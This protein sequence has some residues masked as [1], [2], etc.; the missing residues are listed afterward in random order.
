MK[1]ADVSIKRPVF[2]LM[3]SAA[4]VV[5]GV[6]SYSQLGLDLMPKTDM[7]VVFVRTSLPGASAEEIETQI[8][9]PIEEVVNTIA[10]I[11]ELRSSSEQ[12]SSRVIIMFV[13][14]RDIEA[15]VQDVRD[16]VA[17]ITSR[18]P[19]DTFP[20]TVQKI[21][22][23][24]SPILTVAISGDR[25]QKEISEIV[26]K[27][28]KQV[29]ET[30]NDVGEVTFTGDRRREIQLLLNKDRMVA[31]NLTIDQVRS[32]VQRQNVEI[33][34]GSFIAGSSE[35]ALRTMGRIQKVEDFEKII[36]AYSGGSVIT[37]GDIGRVLDTVEEP[38]SVA[39]M[40]GRQAVSLMVRK[41]SG[42]NTVKVVEAVMARLE[43][44]KTTLPPDLTIQTTQDQS[45][46]I[47]RSFEEIQRHLLL[48]GLL[49]S[50]V[51]LLFMRNFRTTVIA[52][53]AIPTSIIGAFT[54]MRA[55]GFTMNNMTMLALSLATGIVIDDAIVVLENIFRYIEEKKVAPKEAASKAT[56]EIGLAVMATTL[57]LVVIFLP[58]AFMTGQVGRYF[59]SFGIV[60]AGAFLISMFISFTLTPAL[61]ATW[62]RP[63]DAHHGTS[64][65][66]GFYTLVDKTYGKMLGWSM[67]HRVIIVTIG[68]AVV[69]SAALLF[70]R[71]GK[72]L[73]PD[74]DQSEFSVNIR[75]PQGTSFART[76]EYVKP[77]EQEIRNLPHVQNVFANVNAANANFYV[78]LTP[79][80]EREI[81]Q[82]E[83]IRSTR[84]KLSRFRDARISVSGGTDISGSSTAG[85]GRGG[86]GGGG[87]NRLQ[88]LIQGPD[89]TQL[90][91][92]VVELMD[93]VRTIPGVVDVN[94]NF[95][96]TAQEL[97][98]RIDRARAADLGVSIDSLASSLRLLVGGE[99]VSKFKEGDD[100]FAI[101][102][103]LDEQFRN[104]PTKMGD[105]LIPGAGGRPLKVS[106]VAGLT[107]EPGPA[108]IDRYDRQRQ[109]S[110]MGN[111]DGIPMQSA[112]TAAQEKVNEMH[113]KSGYAVQFGFSAKMLS[114]ATDDFWM[115][116]V[117]ALIFIYM[118]LASQFNSF[119]HPLTIMTAIP[120]SLPC[121]L[122]A[123]M[124]FGMTLNVYS[125]I[126][127]M[128]LF[129]IVKKNSILQVDYTNTL[130]AQGMERNEAII[131]ANHVR[132]RPILMT[133]IAIVAGM[134]PIA[135]GR[136]SGSG[137]R[138]SMAVTI[139]G[140]QAI[141]LLLT[142]LVTPVI[143]S[144]F[145]DAK[146]FFRRLRSA[147]IKEI[148]PAKPESTS[149]AEESAG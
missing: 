105:L 86:G 36:I 28:I 46:F 125:A 35:I 83:L 31:Y 111:L 124:A 3:M 121:G 76:D 84:L 18:F 79:L 2:A 149:P 55:F 60:S 148:A 6:A 119:I 29:L 30:V 73:V 16:K 89:I 43:R 62:L 54:L 91:S 19:R 141:C 100:Q 127:L 53:F 95:E 128:M 94:T 17:S 57:S 69:A 135:F 142:L 61:C 143:Y 145:D 109:I 113:L 106:D 11:D 137:S 70:P 5:L 126:G 110:L 66:K 21:D 122:F 107:L 10:G 97:R 49:A 38:R 134:L 118:V 116:L 64:K 20:P 123:L 146:L 71:V 56:N 117:L 23:D 131:T 14:E 140:G 82:Q 45:L 7:P 75:L 85:S 24:A 48:G 22:P 65:T 112:I 98:V 133:T 103:R 59:Y 120:L 130:I 81:S 87:S 25:S 104:D 132:L 63:V 34:G 72:E 37:F 50:I 8:T 96:P 139:I 44:I 88:L 78:Q 114:Q 93:K 90:Q 67:R 12:G 138:A 1:L 4:I 47:R 101:K 32:A 108:T 52:A 136:G 80:E 9:K 39:R 58:V 102:L 115:A 40:N 41:Q 27:R 33:P 92:Y 15:A 42:A 129:G 51:V 13:L 144:L 77:I 147:E 68:L 74:D 26:D 99:E